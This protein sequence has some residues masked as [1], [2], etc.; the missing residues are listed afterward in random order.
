M[1]RPQL[2]AQLD[3][4]NIISYKESFIDPKDGALCIVTSFCEDGD[5]FTRIRKRQ[6]ANNQLFTEDEV[7]DMFVQVGRPK[8]SLVPLNLVQS[9]CG[10]PSMASRGRAAA[11]P[12]SSSEPAPAC[13]S[14]PRS[15]TSTASVSCT[16]T[17]R[18]KT[19]F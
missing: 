13:R 2:L 11:I 8:W 5:L 18:R 19:S 7:M 10:A 16:A 14:R 1:H 6:Q 17:S 3:H 15:C 9:V 4:P 12:P